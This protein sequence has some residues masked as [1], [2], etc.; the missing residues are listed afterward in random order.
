[1]VLVT[2][3]RTTFV[4]R[5]ESMSLRGRFF[6]PIGGPQAHVTLRRKSPMAVIPAKLVLRESGGAGIQPAWTP[7]YAG[8]TTTGISIPIGGP[9]AH[10]TLVPLQMQLARRICYSSQICIRN[11]AL[12]SKTVMQDVDRRRTCCK[13]EPQRDGRELRR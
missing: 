12:L 7:A 11:S 10:V 2:L 9:K 5:L 8:V 13:P 1:M 6:I 4:N 3:P